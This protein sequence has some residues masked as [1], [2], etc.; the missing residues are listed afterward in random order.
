M[1]FDAE[2][3]VV[4]EI[5]GRAKARSLYLVLSVWPGTRLDK[6]HILCWIGGKWAVIPPKTTKEAIRTAAEE[7]SQRRSHPPQS[8]S[9]PL[10]VK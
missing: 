5:S 10:A 6:L 9:Q 2:N 4:T 8:Y 1:L 7:W 3:G